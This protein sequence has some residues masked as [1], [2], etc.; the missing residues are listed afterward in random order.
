MWFH[1]TRSH[2]HLFH[3]IP[4][5]LALPGRGTMWTGPAASE[6]GGRWSGAWARLRGQTPVGN[7]SFQLFIN[8]CQKLL[9][10]CFINSFKT[11]LE[12]P[13]LFMKLLFVR[14]SVAW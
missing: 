11:P 13:I 10:N 12:S 4:G 2:D 8:G 6:P 9:D 14:E 5:R 3:G 7:T 1:F